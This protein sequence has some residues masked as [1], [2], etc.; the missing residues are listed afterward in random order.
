MAFGD[1]PAGSTRLGQREFPARARPLAN[2]WPTL[3]HAGFGMAGVANAS[4]VVQAGHTFV[5]TA[6]RRGRA[7][8]VSQVQPTSANLFSPR[9]GSPSRGGCAHRV[10]P[11]PARVSSGPSHCLR[12][13]FAGP[14]GCAMV[15]GRKRSRQ[16]GRTRSFASAREAWAGRRACERWFRRWT[17]RATGS[18]LFREQATWLLR[19][20]ARRVGS[21][22]VGFR[23][24]RP[25]GRRCGQMSNDAG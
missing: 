17:W 25:F 4:A 21:R 20:H 6:L 11:A 1:S 12:S 7:A 15:R 3:V 13:P 18:P 2:R 14:R 5:A 24:L 23:L 8:L 16:H 9:I 22:S 19:K 10:H